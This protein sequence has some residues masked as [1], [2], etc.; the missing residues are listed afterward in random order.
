MDAAFTQLRGVLIDGTHSHILRQLVAD[1]SGI[2]FSSSDFID[3]CGIMSRLVAY[4]CCRQ[5]Y[6][7]SSSD[8]FQFAPRNSPSAVRIVAVEW[9]S[10]RA[11]G[12]DHALTAILDG[13]QR[14][15]I[16][17]SYW[18]RQRA[19]LL[20]RDKHSFAEAL[21][22]MQSSSV[23]DRPFLTSMQLLS[24]LDSDLYSP[25]IQEKLITQKFRTPSI[26]IQEWIL[27]AQEVI[28]NIK[29]FCLSITQKAV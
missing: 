5:F 15:S 12:G 21:R 19:V 18:N 26:R 2:P 17:Q 23:I 13:E 24:G 25:E 11:A 9:D 1:L 29:S 28:S 22:V 7:E 20:T 14:V 27:P 3:R 16:L 8:V 4:A 6:G 10:I